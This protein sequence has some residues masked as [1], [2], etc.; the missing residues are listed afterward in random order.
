MDGRTRIIQ[1]L[2]RAVQ[3]GEERFTM[4]KTLQEFTDEYKI[5]LKKGRSI[6]LTAQDKTVICEILRSEGVDPNTPPESWDAISRSE[7]L[8]LG[9]NEK[10]AR[11][12]V[13]KWRVAVKALK[14]Q[15]PL[16]LNGQAYTLPARCHIDADY[17][18]LGSLADHDWIVVVENWECFND[19]HIAAARLEFPGRNPVIVWRG[20]KDDVRADSLIT[21]IGSLT[22]P[23]AAFVDYDPAGLVIAKA[24]PRLYKIVAPDLNELRKLMMQ[25][26]E[27]RYLDQLTTCQNAL[28]KCSDQNILELWT[29]IRTAGRALP[30]E[31]FVQAPLLT[32]RSE[33]NK[34]R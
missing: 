10:L 3:S 23:V 21:L 8:R 18:L 16:Y 13:K 32:K 31:Y 12:P 25:G 26:L 30:Q 22:Q 15:L 17:H 24:L 2:L 28:D 34:S 4:S 33:K 5:G 19:I 11:Q 7:A 14:P 27:D 9:N 29:I 6:Y 1:T 20:D